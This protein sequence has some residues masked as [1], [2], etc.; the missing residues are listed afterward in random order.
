MRGKH[1][2]YG[3]EGIDKR[4]AINLCPT[5]GLYRLRDDI[6][7]NDAKV[8]FFGGYPARAWGQTR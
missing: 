3:T 1:L 2:G 7:H 4:M 8:S 6:A 5:A